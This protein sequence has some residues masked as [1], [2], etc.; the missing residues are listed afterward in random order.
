LFCFQHGENCLADLFSNTQ[1][2]HDEDEEEE[3]SPQKRDQETGQPSKMKKRKSDKRK[4]D[5]ENNEKKRGDK[6]REQLFFFFFRSHKFIFF[7]FIKFQG[8]RVVSNLSDGGGL[9][10]KVEC[11]NTL[12]K[13]K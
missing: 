12:T 4:R 3:I 10:W 11:T 8:R 1:H 13:L 6:T 7:V 2:D 5:G 9:R